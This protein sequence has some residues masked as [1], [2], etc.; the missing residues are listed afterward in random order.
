MDDAQKSMFK[1]E[2]QGIKSMIS[3]STA[4]TGMLNQTTFP[5][6]GP[7]VNITSLPAVAQAFRQQADAMDKLVNMI[8]K[9]IN[10]S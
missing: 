3:A 8:E 5:V 1:A 4:A 10:A 7:V 2:L 6:T 9:V